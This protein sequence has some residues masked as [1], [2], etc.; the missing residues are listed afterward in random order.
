[1]LPEEPEKSYHAKNRVTAYD[2]FDNRAIFGDKLLALRRWVE[3]PKRL[4]S[5]SSVN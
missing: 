4:G 5:A 1:M 2:I 3:R